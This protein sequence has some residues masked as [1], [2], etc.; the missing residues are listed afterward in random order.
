VAVLVKDMSDV[1]IITSLVEHGADNSGAA[2]LRIGE[3]LVQMS[4][5][6]LCCT[7]RG[8]RFGVT[9]PA[10]L[11][12][13]RHRPDTA[14]RRHQPRRQRPQRAQRQLRQTARRLP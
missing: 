14:H 8:I 1:N 13:Q 10:A 7:M 5:G 3:K 6:C 4:N 2:L 12:R 11:R 9:R